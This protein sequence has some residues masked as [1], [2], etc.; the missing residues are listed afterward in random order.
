MRMPPPVSVPHRARVDLGEVG[1]QDGV[2]LGA[3][4]PL[5]RTL[6]EQRRARPAQ[7]EDERP[8]HGVPAEIG[9]PVLGDHR[10]RRVDPGPD[11]GA[12]AGIDRRLHAPGTEGV[13]GRFGSGREVHGRERDPP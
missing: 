2:A 7:Q 3:G 8:D 10:L 9:R 1:V 12:K 4:V 11:R 13:A 5:A 6:P